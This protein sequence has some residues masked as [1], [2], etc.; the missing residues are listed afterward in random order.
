MPQVQDRVCG[1]EDCGTRMIPLRALRLMGLVYCPRIAEHI[2]NKR[3]AR[4]SSAVPMF[5]VH[6]VGDANSIPY[7]K[8][9]TLCLMRGLEIQGPATKR[10]FAGV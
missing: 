9:S 4:S 7:M 3:S 5:K 10:P 8:T 1:G 2:A 6:P